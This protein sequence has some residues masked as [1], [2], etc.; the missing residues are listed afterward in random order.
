MQAE[1][2]LWQ[3][4]LSPPSMLS[5]TTVWSRYKK[6]HPAH[7]LSAAQGQKDKTQML[8]QCYS[9]FPCSCSLAARAWEPRQK[10]ASYY[11]TNTLAFSKMNASEMPSRQIIKTTLV[12]VTGR[13]P[14]ATNLAWCSQH[15]HSALM[16]GE[17]VS[18]VVLPASPF[19]KA[20]CG[21]ADLEQYMLPPWTCFIYKNE[22]IKPKPTSLIK[23][24]V[25]VTDPCG[26]SKKSDS[27]N[28]RGWFNTG[29]YGLG[30]IGQEFP[31]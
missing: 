31:N 8:V 18:K 19:H 29:W 4:P 15:F 10:L 25:S 30:K 27:Q 12:I 11:S 26:H 3:A 2:Q 16:D 17:G 23:E 7:L 1:T 22:G 6:S 5:V 28:L 13:P 14:R 9:H 24:M 20:C 21:W